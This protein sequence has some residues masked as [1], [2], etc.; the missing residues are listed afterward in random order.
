M[1]FRRLPIGCPVPVIRACTHAHE[2]IYI[3]MYIYI[4][5]LY[6]HM[7]IYIYTYAFV[8]TRPGSPLQLGTTTSQALKIQHLP[9]QAKNSESKLWVAQAPDPPEALK[10]SAGT[11][12]P[13]EAHQALLLQDAMNMFSHD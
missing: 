6:I 9:V 13:A 11:Q 10:N 12:D 1:E 3:Y 7:Y 5:T 8:H 4:Y 2:Y